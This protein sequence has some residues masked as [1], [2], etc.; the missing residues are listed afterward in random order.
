MIAPRFTEAD[1]NRAHDEW[2]ANC[3]PG[4]I[5]AILALTLDELRPYM[6]DFESKRYTNPTLMWATVRATP[7]SHRR[8]AA[9]DRGAARKR[10]VVP[11]RLSED[12]GARWSEREFINNGTEFIADAK[13]DKAGEYFS[14]RA[15]TKAQ[16]L[17]DGGSQIGKG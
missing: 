14:R 4:A 10:L 5:A 2:G 3:G 7:R 12:T 6:G 13:A 11:D 16:G 8:H 15:V 17:V 1:A 9:Q